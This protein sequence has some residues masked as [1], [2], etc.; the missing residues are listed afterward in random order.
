LSAILPGR[1]RLAL[2]LWLLARRPAVGTLFAVLPLASPVSMHTAIISPRENGLV[3]RVSVMKST[4]H[5][6][7]GMDSPLSAVM[8]VDQ[9]LQR[10]GNDEELLRDIIQVYLE[11]APGMAK[12]I[13]AAVEGDDANGLQRAAHSLKGLASTLSA[14]ELVDVAYRLEHIAATRNLAD[15]EKTAA[16]VDQRVDELS[17]AVKQ[18]LRQK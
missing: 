12:K 5:P 14:H 15:A 18:Y 6:H 3:D 9:A 1:A 4:A 13:H 16:E 2:G 8:D 10:L 17:Q 7:A 11:D